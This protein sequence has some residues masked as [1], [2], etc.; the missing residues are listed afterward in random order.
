ME[1]CEVNNIINFYTDFSMGTCYYLW[2]VM[3]KEFRF[4]TFD[5]TRKEMGRFGQCFML[6]SIWGKG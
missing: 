1:L 2:Q 6:L 5:Q 4:D 3:A